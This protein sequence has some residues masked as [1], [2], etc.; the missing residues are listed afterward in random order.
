MN[1]CLCEDTSKKIEFPF[2]ILELYRCRPKKVPLNML[3]YRSQ[4]VVTILVNLVNLVTK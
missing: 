1:R 2:N 3:S 4:N